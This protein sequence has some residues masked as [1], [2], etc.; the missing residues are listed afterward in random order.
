[1]IMVWMMRRVFSLL[2]QWKQDLSEFAV[3]Y[4]AFVFMKLINRMGLSFI[5][6]IWYGQ[7]S[8]QTGRKALSKKICIESR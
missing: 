1:M 8:T 5:H 2:F 7:T 4:L 3:R 6:M